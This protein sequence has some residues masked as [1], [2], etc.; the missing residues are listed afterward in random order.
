MHLRPSAQLP[1]N[2]VQLELQL[3]H[4]DAILCDDVDFHRITL[5]TQVAVLLE[6]NLQKVD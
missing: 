5:G 2:L 4:S 6:K 3:I 1:H